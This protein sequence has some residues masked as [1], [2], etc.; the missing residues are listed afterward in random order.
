[1]E[2]FERLSVGDWELLRLTTD[3]VILDVVPQLGGTVVSLRRREDDVELLWRTPWGLRPRGSLSVPGSSEAAML[4]TYP[5]GWQSLFPNAGET[6]IVHGVEWG[7]DGEARLA[8]F[9]WTAVSGAV[10]LRCRLVRS[11]FE[12]TKVISV[13]GSEVKV[14]ETVTNV[15]GEPLEVMWGQQVVFGQPLISA[16]TVVDAEATTVYPDPAV[17][18]NVSYEDVL[19]WPRSYG[20]EAVINLR[21]L[22]GPET[23]QT[24]L[25][26]IT[27]FSRPRLTIRNPELDLGVDLEWDGETWP[28]LWYSLEAGLRSDFPWY[29]KGYFFS[30]TPN[31]S[32][33]GHGIYDARQVNQ[34]TL[35][36]NAEE[37]LTAH[38]TVRVHSIS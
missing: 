12:V 35:W 11:P 5:G 20:N 2:G 28:H 30:V 26:Y 21:N 7:A 10:V 31:T 34:S 8:P 6:S 14:A 33:P 32:W 38:L 17:S 29:N 1:M 16:E 36:I 4:D 23:G 19:P 24:R 27:D 3:Q 13:R 37:A 9:S 15:G 25:A 22:P 18:V